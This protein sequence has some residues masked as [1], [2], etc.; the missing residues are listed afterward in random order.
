VPLVVHD[1]YFLRGLYS[2]YN[3]IIFSPYFNTFF[4]ELEVPT[5]SGHVFNDSVQSHY[6]ISGKTCAISNKVV[7]ISEIL[8]AWMTSRPVSQVWLAVEHLIHNL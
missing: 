6:C 3:F 7:A 4:P 2:F 1:C 5:G 8:N